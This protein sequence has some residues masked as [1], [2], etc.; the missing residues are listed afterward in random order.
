MGEME[1]KVDGRS[2][3]HVS[4]K[5]GPSPSTYEASGEALNS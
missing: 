4:E 1:T 2:T 5:P 3:G